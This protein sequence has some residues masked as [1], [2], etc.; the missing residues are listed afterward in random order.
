MNSQPDSPFPESTTTE[1]PSSAPVGAAANFGF[2]IRGVRVGNGELLELP[3]PGSVIAVVGANNVGKTTF[4]R[5]TR[6]ILE[7]G[8]LTKATTP[9]VVTELAEPW[10]GNEQDFAAWLIANARISERAGIRYVTRNSSNPQIP[11]ENAVGIRTRPTPNGVAHWFISNLYPGDRE[12]AIGMV[13]RAD[14]SSTPEHPMQVL[15]ADTL[16]RARIQDL[17][18]RMFDVQLSFD[19]VSQSVGFRVGKP[20]VDG[21]NVTE[22]DYEYLAAMGDLPPLTSQG[23]GI[24]SALGQLVHV[25]AHLNPLAVV[26]EPEAFLHPPQAELLGFEIAR[27][28][29]ESRSQVVLATHDK[30]LLQ[31]LAR[32]QTTMAILHLRRSGDSTT[33]IR[34]TA[35][36]IKDLWKDAILRYGNALDSL[37]HHAVII[38]EADRDSHFYHAAIDFVRDKMDPKPRAHNLMFLSSYGKQNMAGIVERLRKLG[39]R[40]VT[41]PDLDILNDEAKL[42]RLVTAHGGDWNSIK[43]LYKQATNEFAGPAKPP[44]VDEVRTKIEEAFSKNEEAVLNKP[45]A[46]ALAA[47]VS[48]PATNWGKLK[49]AGVRAF[50]QDKTAATELLNA[51]DGMG[52][53]SVQVGELENFITTINPPRGPELLPAALAA[54]A[55]QTAEAQAHANRLLAAAEL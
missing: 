19:N 27:I 3:G 6:E 21:P 33:V 15:F 49:E 17:A 9:P 12:S 28:A 13:N 22:V 25:I 1:P 23:D 52:I 48:L 38:C 16:K 30:N 54:G 24:K 14:P 26:D 2:A 40:T 39:V 45:L 32:S 36:D 50:K 29:R 42:S 43:Q 53:V 37:F 18:L 31:G 20:A 44:A 11:F 10:V 41:S 8:S 35:D 46:K 55:H 7:S 34:L 5:Q 4:L 47:A 51:L